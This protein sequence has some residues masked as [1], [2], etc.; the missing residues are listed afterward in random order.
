MASSA[1]AIDYFAIQKTL[2]DYCFA[3]DTKD[4][5]R[6]AEVFTEDVVATYPFPGGDMNGLQHIQ[7]VIS[8]R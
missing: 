4:F 1:G 8:S 3:L 7:E 5:P 2:A 6:L